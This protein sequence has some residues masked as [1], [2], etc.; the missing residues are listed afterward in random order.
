MFSVLIINWAIN[1]G[2]ETGTETLVA[3][4]PKTDKQK[5]EEALNSLSRAIQLAPDFA[6]C[7]RL[8]G[9]CY[10][11]QGKKNEACEALNKAKEL[12]DPVA[13]KMIKEHC[14]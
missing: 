3:D 6:S 5:Y 4:G 2:N 1:R 10:V 8:R 11:R 9:V 13:E 12:G 14:K 7:Y